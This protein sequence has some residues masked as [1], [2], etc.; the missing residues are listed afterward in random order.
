MSDVF[1]FQGHNLEAIV[2][3]GGPFGSTIALLLGLF[4]LWMLIDAYNSHVENYWYF[5]ILFLFPLGAV[6]YFLAVKMRAGS[7]LARPPRAAPLFDRRMSLD[8]LRHRVQRSPTVAN[9]LHLADRLM[10]KKE[11]AEAVPHLEGILAVEPHYCQ[12]LYSLAEC[13]LGMEQTDQAIELLKRLLDKEPRWSNYKAWQTLVEAYESKSEPALALDACRKLERY[14]PTLQTKCLLAEHLLA[15]RLNAEAVKLLDDA[16]E[17]HRFASF[18]KKLRD[19]SWSRRA[20]ALLREAE[21]G[22]PAS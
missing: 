9:R 16:L 8:E 6:L 20:T 1:P 4:T 12:A 10:D 21:T 3:W 22:T 11:F 19:W 18:G 13:R 14:M 5:V 2:E 7:W 15:N 17:D